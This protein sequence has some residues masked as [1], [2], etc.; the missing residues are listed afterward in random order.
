MPTWTPIQYRGFWDVPRI[1]L[2]A[3]SDRLFLFDCAF[4][5]E[6]DDYPDE[7]IVFVLP[8]GTDDSLPQDWTTLVDRATARLGTVP[9]SEVTF[10]PTRRQAIDASILDRF[11]PIGPVSRKQFAGATG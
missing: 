1:F 2:V 3:A 4:S 6:L 5:E 7:Y 10:D 9:V 11:Q 8:E